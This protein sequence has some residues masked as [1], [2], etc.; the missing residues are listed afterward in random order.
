[1]QET[2][3][4]KGEPEGNAYHYVVQ[5]TSDSDF[6]YILYSPFST[7]ARVG[8]WFTADDLDEYLKDSKS[9]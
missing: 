1:M 6:P 3:P 8:H 4:K 9:K 7:E 5:Q 2:N